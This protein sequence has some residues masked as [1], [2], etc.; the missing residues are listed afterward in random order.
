MDKVSIVKPSSVWRN[1][2]NVLVNVSLVACR[3]R[4]GVSKTDTVN[5]HII[6]TSKEFVRKW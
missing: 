4:I 1:G 3:F 2:A 6:S 5:R